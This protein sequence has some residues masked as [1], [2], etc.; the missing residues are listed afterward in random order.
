MRQ[1]STWPQD[2]ILGPTFES[3]DQCRIDLWGWIFWI[4]NFGA[5]GTEV[6]GPRIGSLDLSDEL[7][8]D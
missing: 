5:N 7:P 6:F 2:Q 1:L 3:L 8:S 4:R